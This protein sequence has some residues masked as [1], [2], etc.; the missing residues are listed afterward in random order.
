MIRNEETSNPARDIILQ[1]AA[2]EPFLLAAILA[3]G[4]NT[5]YLKYKRPKMNEH[6]G[7]IYLNV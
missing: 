7:H 1:T 4:A 2:T 5:C 6:M 3:E